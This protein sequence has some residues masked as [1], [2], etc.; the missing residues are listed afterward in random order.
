MAQVRPPVQTAARA[1][2][3]VL[4]SSDPIKNLIEQVSYLDGR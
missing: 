2:G 4:Q 3:F 1:S